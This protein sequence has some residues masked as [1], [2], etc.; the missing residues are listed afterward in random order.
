MSTPT[1]TEAHRETAQAAIDAAFDE[2][3]AIVLDDPEAQDEW[4]RSGRS[5]LDYTPEGEAVLVRMVAAYI[6]RCEAAEAEI[7]SLK[8]WMTAHARL[9]SDGECGHLQVATDMVLRRLGAAEA[10]VRE[11]EAGQ[12]EL[13]REAVQGIETVAKGAVDVMRRER[14]E[15]RAERDNATWFIEQKGYRRCDI[16]ACNCPYWHGGNA[17]TRLHEVADALEDRVQGSTILAAVVKVVEGHDAA[18]AR[19]AAAL[20]E[21]AT[22]LVKQA[23]DPPWMSSNTAWVQAIV[24]LR[25]ALASTTPPPGKLIGPEVVEA[26]RHMVDAAAAWNR[27]YP[28]RRVRGG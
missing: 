23:F 20:R 26:I 1:V 2:A 4:E 15:A 19:E 5:H 25:K 7:V 3:N 6:A 22:E 21:A 11:L 24:R 16:P 10:R 13:V 9:L 14:D 8:E 18:L 17:E 28:I 27:H 12:A